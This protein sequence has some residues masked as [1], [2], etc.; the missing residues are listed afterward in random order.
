[1]VRCRC[2]IAL[3]ITVVLG[4]VSTATGGLM[5]VVYFIPGEKN[6]QYCMAAASEE[7]DSAILIDLCDSSDDKQRWGWPG[8]EAPTNLI[9]NPGLYI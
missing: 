7:E 8:F 2:E 4:M 9:K 3:L 6:D 5:G 1:M